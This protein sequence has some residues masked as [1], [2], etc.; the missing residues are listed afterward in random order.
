MTSR[1]CSIQLKNLQGSKFSS[2][3][4]ILN[5]SIKSPLI[6]LVSRAVIFKYFN[7]SSY[8]LCLSEK[9]NLVAL[10]CT[11][12]IKSISFWRYWLEHYGITGKLLTFISA[13]IHNREQCVVLDN[14]FSS[15]TSVL[16][17]VPQG[18]VLGPVLFFIFIN[19]VSS[20]CI[21]QAKLKLFADDVKLYSS[22]NVDVSE[23][24]DLQQSLDLL[25]SWAN[26]WQLNINI[27]KCSVLF[28]HHNS[29]SRPIISHPYFINESQ[30]TNSSSVTDL[31]ILVDSHLTIILVIFSPKERGELV[32]SSVD[33]HHAIL[34]L[35]KRHL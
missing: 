23:C 6:L 7:L 11:P 10:R 2:P 28:V 27:S 19:D 26:S 4:K 12:S 32:S 35:W 29:K 34:P 1:R 9:I 5:T 20:T 8:D 21:G 14:C 33:F 22:F 18:S 13:F 25:P 30:L 24:G 16:S 3:L 17:G 31:G 15:F